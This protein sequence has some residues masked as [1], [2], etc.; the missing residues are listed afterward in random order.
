MERAK[1]L[2]AVDVT[3][4]D[5][6][7]SL[8]HHFREFINAAH[9]V[10]AGQQVFE[11]STGYLG[12]GPTR[13]IATSDELAIVPGLAM[14]IVVRR[15]SDL[16]QYQLLGPCY[17]HGVMEGELFEQLQETECKDGWPKLEII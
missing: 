12:L 3:D 17:V 2:Q 11:T 1:P 6:G 15:L 14:P 9:L 8:A 13:E 4:I 7:D 10:S 16:P 5:Q